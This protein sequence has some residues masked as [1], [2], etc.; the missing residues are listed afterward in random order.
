MEHTRR[1]LATSKASLAWIGAL[2]LV[3][4]G[5][6]KASSPPADPSIVVEGQRQTPEEIRRAARE[7][8]RKSGIAQ[9]QTPA[10]RWRVPVCAKIVGLHGKPAELVRAKLEAEAKAAGVPLARPGCYGNLAIVFT[11]DGAGVARAIGRKDPRRTAGVPLPTLRSIYQSE[12][13]VRWWYAVGESSTSGVSAGTAELPWTG[14]NAEGGGSVIPSNGNNTLLR[15]NG[16]SLVST[17]VERGITQ[18]TVIVDV[19][20]ATGKALDAVA[21]YVAMVALAEVQP[22]K[23]PSPGSIL[24]LFEADS[25]QIDL[26]DRDRDLLHTLYRLPLDRTALNHRSRL[27]RGVAAAELADD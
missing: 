20:A 21:A 25:S 26:S 11:D 19:E 12:A 9:G 16:S 2:T 24:S 14:G 15:H 22:R 6:V 13:P 3:A 1:L 8:V 10:A 7:F 23:D 4:A 18:A 5:P 27:S 17:L